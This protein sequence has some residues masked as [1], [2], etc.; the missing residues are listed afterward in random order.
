M[1]NRHGRAEGAS[2]VVPDHGRCAGRRR[3]D[4]PQAAVAD[5]SAA[6][7][8]SCGATVAGEASYGVATQC[9]ETVPKHSEAY[10]ATDSVP[11]PG[12]PEVSTACTRGEFCIC[13]T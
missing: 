3:T 7:E 11:R 5:K 8:A 9:V 1:P 6:E 2:A 13:L 12:T 10:E 4:G